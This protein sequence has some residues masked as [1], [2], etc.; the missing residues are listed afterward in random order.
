MVIN[1]A[2]TRTADE[3]DAGILA[4]ERTFEGETILVVINT[5]D[6]TEK[7][8]YSE[9]S[10]EG[11]LMQTSFIEGNTLTNVFPDEDANDEVEVG[12]NGMVDIRVPCRGGKIFVLKP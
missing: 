6:C 10:F 5:E 11:S 4:Y 8:T 9:T 3:L 1:W 12:T 7:K 2:T